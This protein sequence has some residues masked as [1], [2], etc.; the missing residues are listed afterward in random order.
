MDESSYKQEGIILPGDID[1]IEFDTLLE[2]SGS[3]VSFA[4]DV[5]T[6]GDKQYILNCVDGKGAVKSARFTNHEPL[7]FDS[8]LWRPPLDDCGGTRCDG[9]Y[10]DRDCYC[11]RRFEVWSLHGE[12]FEAKS[13]GG[14]FAF[15]PKEE[16]QGR[17]ITIKTLNTKTEAYGRWT[18]IQHVYCFV[19]G[20]KYPFATLDI[21]WG[22]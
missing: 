14:V 1:G 18:I 9:A 13:E 12:Y 11:A 3:K 8:K 19:E 17:P 22:D 16:H 20:V 6:D 2:F 15:Q 7:S 10:Y 21:W 5:E 4:V